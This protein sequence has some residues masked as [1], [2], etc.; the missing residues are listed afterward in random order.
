[1]ENREKKLEL[2]NRH[3]KK[4]DW[5][6]EELDNDGNVKQFQ[7]KLVHTNIIDDIPGVELETDYENIVGPTLQL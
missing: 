5:D 7:Q 6:N 3:R 4:F 1:M 2:I